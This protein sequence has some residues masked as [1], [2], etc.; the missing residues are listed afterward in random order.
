MVTITICCNKHTPGKLAGKLREVFEAREVQLDQAA[1][2]ILEVRVHSEPCVHEEIDREQ[3][4][5]VGQRELE[6]LRRV[7]GEVESEQ[8]PEVAYTA[9]RDHRDE[10]QPEVSVV[11]REPVHQLHEREGDRVNYVLLRA[12][13]S[14][15]PRGCIEGF[16][17]E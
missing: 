8:S 3:S 9:E 17:R 5:E 12:I 13:T 10:R 16:C 7:V 2:A 6:V 15:C 1:Q 4:G 14:L 11:L